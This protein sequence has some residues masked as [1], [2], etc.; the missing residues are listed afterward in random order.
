MNAL[1][2]YYKVPGRQVYCATLRLWLASTILSHV[3]YRLAPPP[4][5]ELP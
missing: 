4:L 1:K 2:D 3:V 5:P